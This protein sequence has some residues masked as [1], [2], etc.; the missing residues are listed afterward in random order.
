M[1]QCMLS[2]ALQRRRKRK[3]IRDQTRATD[4]RRHFEQQTATLSHEQQVLS[5]DYVV[6]GAGAVWGAR[7]AGG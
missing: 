2:A 4:C 6:G 3:G 7:R 5:G 1:T